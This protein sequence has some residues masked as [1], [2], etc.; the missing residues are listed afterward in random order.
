[1]RE[2]VASLIG[3]LDCCK[4]QDI[5]TMITSNHHRPLLLEAFD[6]ICFVYLDIIYINM[7]DSI[8]SVYIYVNASTCI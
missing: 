7:L 3:L 2:S 1:M 6:L 8:Y 4:S 5:T